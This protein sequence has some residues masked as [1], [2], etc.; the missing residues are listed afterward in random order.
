MTRDC[1]AHA[2]HPDH[3]VRRAPGALCMAGTWECIPTREVSSGEAAYEL[4]P[5]T[6]VFSPGELVWHLTSTSCAALRAGEPSTIEEPPLPDFGGITA[7]PHP[8]TA[9]IWRAN[10][11]DIFDP[12]VP[13]HVAFQMMGGDGTTYGRQRCP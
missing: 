13:Y 8:N 6:S 9:A 5:T 12:G 1:H 3:L 2:F 10:M 11:Q 7:S 4:A